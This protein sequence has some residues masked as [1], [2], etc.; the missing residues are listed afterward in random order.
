MEYSLTFIQFWSKIKLISNGLKH[1][2]DSNLPYV[3]WKIEKLP[4]ELVMSL[5]SG[6][7]KHAFTLAEALIF[8][9]EKIG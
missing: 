3:S 7:A 2:H 8:W 4:I 6:L 9:K 5:M 1:A